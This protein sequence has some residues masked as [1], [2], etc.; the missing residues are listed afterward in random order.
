MN[1]KDQKRVSTTEWYDFIGIMADILPNL[2]PGGLGATKELLELCRLNSNNRVL[3]VGCG[4][5]STACLIAST[6][7][8]QVLGIDISEVMIS[9]ARERAARK[10]LL[11]KT[12]FRT[13]DVFDLP[14]NDD[15]FDVVIVE[16]VLTPLPG[17][18]K[19]AMRELCRV[20]KVGGFIGVN[21]GT[22]DPD[23]PQEM[24]DILVEHPAIHGTFTLESLQELFEDSGMKVVETRTIRQQAS[25]R[26]IEG[27]GVW[28]WIK[29][30]TL[31]YPKLLIRLIRD[32]EIRHASKIDGDL[33]KMAQ[34]YMGFVL[35]VGKKHK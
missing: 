29:F 20:V 7:G 26:M 1:E 32:K 11:D 6:Y 22:F 15:E 10:G 9:R 19:V 14:F 33:T 4:S 28:D 18:K 31:V 34:E 27:M 5:G 2:H 35:I 3:D 23:C 12:D 25:P 8:C 24:L 30:M 21:E 13:A 16:S 17:D